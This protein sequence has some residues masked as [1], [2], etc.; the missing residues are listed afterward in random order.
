MALEDFIAG[1]TEICS[2]AL[3]REAC[4]NIL[5][6]E[7]RRHELRYVLD[8][9]VNIDSVFLMDRPKLGCKK[10]NYCYELK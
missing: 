10:V 5:A 6:E 2:S 7:A 8:Q 3:S 9:A 4:E 1:K